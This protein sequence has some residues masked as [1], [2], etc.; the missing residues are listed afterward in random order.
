MTTTTPDAWTAP[1]ALQPADVHQPLV[2]VELDDVQRVLD[3][4]RPAIDRQRALRDSV[5]AGSFDR[6]I[7][8]RIVRAFERTR[9]AAEAAELAL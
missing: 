6:A 3:A 4:V 5:D 7:A 8:H 2:V 9:D 1:P